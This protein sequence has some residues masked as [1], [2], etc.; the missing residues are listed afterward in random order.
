MRWQAL[1]KSEAEQ[2][3]IRTKLISGSTIG[4]MIYFQEVFILMIFSGLMG[5]ENQLLKSLHTCACCVEQWMY[6][7][8]G[9]IGG[10]GQEGKC[11]SLISR[12]RQVFFKMEGC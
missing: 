1:L 5:Y 9:R 4:I 11:G 7:R 3:K 2:I 6:N 10:G 8:Q 12:E